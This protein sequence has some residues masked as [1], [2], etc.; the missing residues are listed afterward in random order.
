MLLERDKDKDKEKKKAWNNLLKVKGE[1]S[2]KWWSIWGR[3]DSKD[4]SKGNKSKTPPHS[5]SRSSNEFWF[6][7]IVLT[8]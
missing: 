6:R 3:K 5:K 1:D 2:A 4:K 8:L 7:D